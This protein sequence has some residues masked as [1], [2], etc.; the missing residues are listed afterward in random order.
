M[1][2]LVIISVYI[3]FS[4]PQVGNYVQMYQARFM[5]ISD[6]NQLSSGRSNIWS[7]YIKYILEH[8]EVLL[9]GNGFIRTATVNGYAAHNTLIQILFQCGITGLIGLFIW[10]NSIKRKA[11]TP[12]LSLFEK[13]ILFIAIFFPWMSLDKL[14]FDDFFFLIMF[15][16]IA[17][18]QEKEISN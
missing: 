11:K 17:V 2:A 5:G 10:L 16:I 8:V 13:V 7:E 4:M 12:Y 1:I 14:F 6:M 3:F 15:Y 9:F 18:G